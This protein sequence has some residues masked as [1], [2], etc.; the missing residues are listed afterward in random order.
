MESVMTCLSGAF[1]S[2][3]TQVVNTSAVYLKQGRLRHINDGANA[4]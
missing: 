2:N 3:R 4:P 1:L